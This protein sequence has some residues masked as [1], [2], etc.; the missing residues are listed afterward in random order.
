MLKSFYLSCSR[1]QR[2]IEIYRDGKMMPIRNKK[3]D[4]WEYNERKKVILYHKFCRLVFGYTYYNILKYHIPK[5][6]KID[7]NKPTP[8]TPFSIWKTH[9]NLFTIVKEVL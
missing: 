3:K 2:Y 6:Q 8:N 4:F 9:L 5:F 1:P 7:L